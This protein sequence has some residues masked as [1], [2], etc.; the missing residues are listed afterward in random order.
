LA[1]R[2]QIVE[3]IMSGATYQ[4]IG[5]RIGMSGQSVR[6]SYERRLTDTQRRIRRRMQA[7]RVLNCRRRKPAPQHDATPVRPAL[8]DPLYAAIDGKLPRGLPADL[9]DEI[10]SDMYIFALERRMTA[11]QV[12]SRTRRFVNRAYSKWAS[13]FGP[14]SLDQKLIDDAELT[15]LDLLADPTAF[16]AFNRLDDVQ[17]GASA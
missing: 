6:K 14:L 11:E 8:R 16:D 17:L 3:L 7:V 9:R 5:E 10:V 15:R 2:Q 12:C 4:E 1:R 13:K